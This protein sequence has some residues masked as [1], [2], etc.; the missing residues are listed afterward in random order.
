MVTKVL[1]ILATAVHVAS[2]TVVTM[3]S[4]YTLEQMYDSTY[5]QKS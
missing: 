2:R 4:L 5:I 1:A 3:L